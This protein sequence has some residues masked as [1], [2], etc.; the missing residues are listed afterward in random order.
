MKRTKIFVDMDGVLVNFQ[1]GIGK[2]DETTKRECTFANLFQTIWQGDAC[3][4][5]TSLKCH[6]SNHFKS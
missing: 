3:Q 5:R 4:A 1:S 6:F 2:L